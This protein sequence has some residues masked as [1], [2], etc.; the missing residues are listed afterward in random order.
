MISTEHDFS[1]GSEQ[2]A[3]I[4][5]DLAEAT[6][7]RNRTPWLVVVGHRPL[8]CSSRTFADRCTVEATRYR[9]YL[10]HLL[11]RYKIDIYMCGHNH[12]YERSYPVFTAPSSVMI[13]RTRAQPRT[14]STVPLGIESA[15]IRPL[16]QTSRCLGERRTDMGSIPAGWKWERPKLS[17]RSS[18][19]SARMEKW[20]IT[21]P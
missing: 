18:T 6:D 1:I 9:S 7:N 8:Y 12:Q 21:S 13:T 4:E 17:C 19:C 3:W 15:T 20:M 10:E 16:S 14:L 11:H 5:A 2:H